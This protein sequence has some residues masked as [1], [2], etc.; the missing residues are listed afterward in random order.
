MKIKLDKEKGNICGTQ[1]LKAGQNEQLTGLLQ[2]FC[3]LMD[4]ISFGRY[5][6]FSFFKFYISF[7]TSSVFEL[8]PCRFGC[9]S[10]TFLRCLVTLN[11]CSLLQG[12]G[13]KALGVGG[14]TA[15]SA[16]RTQSSGRACPENSVSVSSVHMVT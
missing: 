7:S 14:R 13:S 2:G 10:E 6:S 8:L 3:Y 11:V 12:R 9:L 15:G 16:L 4:S 5:Y 1:M